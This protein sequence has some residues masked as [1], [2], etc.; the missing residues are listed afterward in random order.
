MDLARWSECGASS[1]EPNPFFEP[2]WLLPALEYLDESPTTML[3]LAEHRGSVQAFVPIV[4]VNADQSD[5]ACDDKHS[6][7]LTRASPTAVTLGTPLVTAEGGHEAL[8][9]LMAAIRGE[10]ERR[11]ASL[12]VM[13]WVE[14]D[15]PTAQLLRDVSIGTKNPLV[16]FDVWERGFLRRQVGDNDRYW[17][18]SIG[19]NRQ[20]TIRQHHRQLSAA[21]GTCPRLRVRTDSAAV[22]AFLRLEASGWKGHRPGGLAFRRQAA[23][24]TFFEVVCDRH[25]DDGRMWF[26][27][28]EGDS[29]P[30]AMICCIRAREGVFA[31]R[32][33]YDEAFAR[34]GPGVEVFLAAVEHFHR[35]TDAR[36]FDTCSAPGN[37]HLLALFPDRRSMSTLMFRVASKCKRANPD[38]GPR[39]A[40]FLPESA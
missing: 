11:G 8:A 27:S 2:D 14:H 38:L 4:A 39:K 1:L 15:G 36:W 34:F 25:L 5:I 40:A 35:E 7:L 37:Q 23:T 21:L 13:E 32:T 12:V 29:T 16:E 3:V 24:T 26:V 30:I 18:R 6:A 22:D 20:R 28:L 31:Y 19:K 10:A 33:A 17:L 9:C